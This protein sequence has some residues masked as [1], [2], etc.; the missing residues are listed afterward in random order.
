MTAASNNIAFATFPGTTIAWSLQPHSVTVYEGAS[1]NFTSLAISDAEFT[2]LYQWYLNNAPVA[3]ATASSFN[4]G[5]IPASYDGAQIKVVATTVIGGLSTTSSVVTLSVLQAVAETGFLRLERWNNQTTLTPLENG[6][7]GVPDFSMAIPAFGASIDNPSGDND[8]VRRISGYFIAPSNGNYVFY[9]TGDDDSDLFLST[10]TTPANKRLVCQQAGWNNGAMWA[11][12]QVG[13]GGANASQM[14]SSTWSPDG[15]TT[16]WAAGIPLVAG[17]KYYIEQ[18]W[19]QGGGGANNAA[20]FAMINDPDP[21]SGTPTRLTGSAIAMSAVRCL[22]VAFTQEPTNV[23]VQPMGYATFSATGTT[24]S[25]TPIGTIYGF[26]E[27]QGTNYLFFQWYKNGV[28]IPGANSKSITL[29]PLVPSDNGAQI[30]CTMRALGYANDALTPI[31]SNS[32]TATITISPQAVFEPGL[33]KEDWWTNITSRLLV[34]NGSVGNPHFTYTTPM[35]EGPSGIGNGNGPT[36]DYAQ[37]ISGFF[38]PPATD[39]YTFFTDSDDDSDFFISTDASPVNKRLVAQEAGWSSV[40]NWNSAGGGGSTVGQKRSD[41][42][43]PDG[44]TVPYSSGISLNGG[45]LYYIEQVHHNGAAGGTHTTATFKRFNDSDPANGDQT[46]F[47]TNRIG[48]YVPRIQW[49]AFL[50]QPNSA[51]AVSGGNSVTFTVAGTNDPVPLKIGTTDNPLTFI[52]TAGSSPLQYQW[53]KNGTPIPGANSASYTLPYVL[54]SDQGAQF[55]CGLRALGYADNSLNRIYSNSVPAVLTVVT[56]TVPPTISYAATFQNTNQNPPEFIVDITFN[57]WMDISTLTNAARYSISGI[58]NITVA[59]NHRTVHLM[60]NAMPTLPLNVT[61]NGVKDLS[62]NSIVGTPSVAINAEKLT[63]SDIGTPGT[64]PAYPSFVWVDGKGGYI[65][66]AEGSD[67]WN[68]NDGCNFGWELKTN[69]FDVVVRGVSETP[70]SEWAKEGL[71][72]RETLDA[73]S[74][75]WSIVNEPLAADGGA[76]RVDTA[77]RDTTGGSSVGWQ[78]TSGDLPPPSYPNA[79]LRLKRTGTVLD[80]FYSTNGLDWVHATAYNT[81]TN[82]TPLGSVVYVGICTTAHNNDV[83]SD[84][85]PSPFLYYNTAEYANYSDFV[86]TPPAAHLSVSR[87]GTDV[88][89]SWTPTGGHL[90]SS[91]AISGAGVNWQP[92]GSGN[93]ASIPLGTGSQFFRVVNP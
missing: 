22:S 75:E 6:S 58:T 35:F 59:S 92:V 18:D 56:D 41:Q 78:L 57:K 44:A 32:V 15:V 28:A 84:P 7:L 52:N 55:V 54:P 14:R 67:I 3:G 48:M 30:Y 12:E 46:L 29:G 77:V 49:V 20:T 31:W 16:P 63:F 90:E 70:T 21:A 11:W 93:P 25:T 8:F 80:G 89:V 38:V 39:L 9:T 4:L 88:I 42:W 72:V 24:D 1:T 73:T 27:A 47:V 37:R 23:T 66:S 60:L 34:E 45:Q 82:A 76:N 5:T 85:A 91:P 68:A 74:R 2:P 13:G 40:R 69:D 87:S 51:T 79:W 64:D 71:M 81:A 36:I 17:H 43:S 33:L 26:E 83:V 65:I 86:P 53:Y 61:V 19:H 62:G 50:Q 10:D